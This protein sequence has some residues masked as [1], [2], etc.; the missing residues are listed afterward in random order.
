MR[1]CNSLVER[2]TGESLGSEVRYRADQAQAQEQAQAQSVEADASVSV[3]SPRRTLLDG[4]RSFATGRGCVVHMAVA[5]MLCQ[6]FA[7]SM[8]GVY[9]AVGKADVPE[10]IERG[11]IG[12]CS[13]IRANG[14]SLSSW[15][16]HKPWHASRPYMIL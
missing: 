1:G 8:L 9:L 10:P 5:T 15:L 14:V 16:P 7:Q 6:A 11:L 3:P 2:I 4:G 13:E 12:I